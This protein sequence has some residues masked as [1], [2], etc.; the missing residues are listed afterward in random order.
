M[1]ERQ[2]FCLSLTQPRDWSGLYR[3]DP[4]D[5]TWIDKIPLYYC[6]ETHQWLLEVIIG[7]Y[8][9]ANWVA[10]LNFNRRKC[11]TKLARE[12]DQASSMSPNDVQTVLPSLLLSRCLQLHL[13]Q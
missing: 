13:I 6:G 3:I 4:N 10:T 7:E 8:S 2:N 9:T 12:L 1:Y 11:N 5:G